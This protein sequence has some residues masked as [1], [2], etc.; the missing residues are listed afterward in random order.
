MATY[1]VGDI[2]GCLQP[3]K[4]LLRAVDFNPSRDVLWSVGDIVN[5]GP[6]CLKTLRFLFEMKDSL[7][8]TLGNHDL[9]LLA[10]AAG[11]RKPSRSD[12]LEKILSA[13]DR[14]QL[15]GWLVQR[16]LIHRE[17]GHTLVHAGIPP[18]WSIPYAIGRAR[19]VETVLQSPD[20]TEFLRT[21]YGNEP[22]IWFEELA[23]MTRLRVITNYLTRMRYCTADGHLDLKS[24][25]PIPDPGSGDVAPWFSHPNR[26]AAEEKILFGH[27]ASL[28]GCTDTPNII[29]LDSGCVWGGALSLYCLDTGEMLRCRCRDGRARDEADAVRRFL[30]TPASG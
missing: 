4:T 13:P 29:G 28:E 25:G 11:V 24:K 3:L 7:V 20:C 16:P 19:E 14:D 22:N 21:M 23:G 27:W 15:L 2:Q 6:R 8:L 12:T 17:H 30:P 5:R 18:Q 10:V 1:A 9:H 26:A